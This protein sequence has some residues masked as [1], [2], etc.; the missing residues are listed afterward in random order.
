MSFSLQQEVAQ[1]PPHDPLPDWNIGLGGGGA[2]LPS[3]QADRIGEKKIIFNTLIKFTK[4]RHGGKYGIIIKIKTL[5]EIN[6]SQCHKCIKI[7]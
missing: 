3:V 7:K 5:S 4:T 6:I 2:L 1:W